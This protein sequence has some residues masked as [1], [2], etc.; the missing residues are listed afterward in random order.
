[1]ATSKLKI[2]PDNRYLKGKEKAIADKQSMKYREFTIPKK[3]GKKRCIVA[4]NEGLKKFQREQLKDLER[5]FYNTLESHHLAAADIFHGFLRGKNCITAAQKH[6][7]YKATL[8]MDIKNF[9]DTVSRNNLPKGL[10]LDSR[11]FHAKGY[12]AQGFPSSPMIANIAA[13][14]VISR[15]LEQSKQNPYLRPYIITVYA[16]DIQISTNHPEDLYGLTNT[17]VEAFTHFGFDINH[18]KT[19]IRYAK[20]GWRRILG[21]NVGIAE[22]RATRKVMRKIR[23]A[24]HQ[25]KTS[26]TAA[27]S[28]GGL[29]TWSKCTLPK[30]K[31]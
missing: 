8:M 12:A 31:K 3:N 5:T 23:A 17:V 22:V 30:S 7:G 24:K 25:S 16:D 1:M 29:T 26:M 6:I 14:P 4:P 9:F 13:V 2:T 15:I 20:H 21:V 18:R 19:R 11:L 27:N 10:E 28:L